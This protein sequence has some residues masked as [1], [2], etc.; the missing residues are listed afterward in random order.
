RRNSSTTDADP[1]MALSDQ[2]A[3]N[4]H[5]TF[6]SQCQQKRRRNSCSKSQSL[7]ANHNMLSQID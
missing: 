5:Q 3:Y 6:P 4:F 1:F 7:S 2:Y